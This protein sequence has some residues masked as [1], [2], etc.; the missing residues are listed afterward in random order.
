MM[1]KNVL[2]QSISPHVAKT[3]INATS[4]SFDAFFLEMIAATVLARELHR[5]IFQSFCSRRKEEHK[6]QTKSFFLIISAAAAYRILNIPIRCNEIQYA[7]SIQ[8]LEHI[9]SK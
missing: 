6:F 1:Q 8:V 4:T 3:A 5:E 9:W 7:S 2:Q